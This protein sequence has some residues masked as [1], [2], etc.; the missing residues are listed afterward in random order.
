MKNLVRSKKWKNFMAKLYGWGAAVVIVGALFKIQHYPGAGPMLFV[1]MTIEAIIFF[2][3]AFEPPHVEPDWSLVYPELAGMYDAEEKKIEGKGGGSL[4]EELDKMLAEAK[5][6]PELISSLG[7]GLKSLSETTSKLND[8]SGAT[9]ATEEYVQ[10]IKG[11][12]KSAGELSDSYK[13]TSEALSKD[14]GAS[15]EYITNIRSASESANVLAN[16]YNQTADAL[17]S[18]LGA[19][20]GYVD[21]IKKATS[22]ANELADQYSKSA[23]S[24]TKSAEA[25]DFSAVDGRAYS[26]QIQKLTQNLSA[27]NSVYELQLQ[28]TNNQR[29]ASGKMQEGIDAFLQH[30][31]ASNENTIRYKE[32]IAAL[33]KNLSAL[34]NVYGNMLAAMNVN[35]NR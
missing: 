14:L 13:K 32:E 3:S 1:G 4:T 34:N 22:S 6:G 27:L 12:S 7:V 11:A 17:K 35:I 33:S 30:L 8:V 10:N 28:E 29:D 9:I 18:D 2:L 23:Q 31:E 26:E 15:D 25:I 21:S 20:Q 16:T 24:L 19:T 5:I